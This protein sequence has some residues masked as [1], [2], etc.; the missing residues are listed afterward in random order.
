MPCI[1]WGY[2]VY[3][4]Y[5]YNIGTLYSNFKKGRFASGY[6]IDYIQHSIFNDVRNMDRNFVYIQPSQLEGTFI[7]RTFG[8]LYDGI[9]R[10]SFRKCCLSCSRG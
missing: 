7:Q 3:C 10:L 1:L 4:Y 8:H 5:L 9:C 2:M 6:I